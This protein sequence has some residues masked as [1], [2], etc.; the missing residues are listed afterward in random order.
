M[1]LIHQAESLTEI[2]KELKL[3]NS[4]TYEELKSIVAKATDYNI[5]I[6]QVENREK[7]LSNAGEKLLSTI[8]NMSSGGGLNLLKSALGLG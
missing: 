3:T 6:S 8:G 4:A 5:A 1:R 2:F 7:Q